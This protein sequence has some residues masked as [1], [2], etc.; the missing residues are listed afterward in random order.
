MIGFIIFVVIST[1]ALINKNIAVVGAMFASMILYFFGI[2]PGIITLMG[3]L[4]IG[5]IILVAMNKQP[6]G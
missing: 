4:S 3:I 6:S 2:I 1:L 5:V